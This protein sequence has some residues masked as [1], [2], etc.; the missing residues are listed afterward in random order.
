MTLIAPKLEAPVTGPLP[1]MPCWLELATADP[2][3]TMAFYAAVFGWEYVVRQDSDGADYVLAHLAGEPVAGIRPIEQPV[4]DWTVYLATYD[5]DALLRQ[6]EAYGGEVLEAGHAVPGVGIKSLVT[7]PAGG[8]FGACQVTTD[9]AYTAG[10]PGS[11]AW[12]EYVTGQTDLADGF[13]GALFDYEQRQFEE[14]G[15]HDYMVYYAGQ[16]SVIG[17]VP[18]IEGTPEHVP[19]RWV[20]HFLLNPAQDF[21][22]TVRVAH[23]NGARLR[24]RPYQTT[25]GKVAVLSDA[26]GA[27]FAVIDPSQASPDATFASTA[28]DPYDD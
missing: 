1:G 4:R 13:F 23:D 24:F 12:V 25:L 21:E 8:N 26:G 18:M 10:V 3:T 5:M 19:A 9:W 27:A 17:R 16:D 6:A 11:L 15:L 14:G 20:A 22:T 7:A 28:D 2:D